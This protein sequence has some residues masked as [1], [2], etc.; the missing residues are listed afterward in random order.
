MSLSGA[1]G[2]AVSGML[3][4]QRQVEVTSGNVSNAQTEGFTAKRA[5]TTTQVLDGRA[6]G[7]LVSDITR[8]GDPF[9]QR[10]LRNEQSGLENAQTKSE[11]FKRVQDLFGT[12]DDDSA[13]ANTLGDLKTRFEEL[14]TEPGNTANQQQVVRQAESVARQ[15]NNL[16]QQ[17][18]ELRAQADADIETAVQT[19]NDQLEN[20]RDLNQNIANADASGDPSANLKDKRDQ[21][22][23]KISQQLDIQTFTRDNG[24]VSVF[25]NDGQ[26]LLNAERGELSFQRTGSFQPGASGNPVEGVDGRNLSPESGGKIGALLELRDQDLPSF[27]EDIDRLAA[28]V[29]EE[30]NAVHNQGTV[31]NS[32][33]QEI[34]GSNQIVDEINSGN[35]QAQQVSVSGEFRIAT[36]D[37]SGNVQ[38]EITIDSSSISTSASNGITVDGS[39]VNGVSGN[40]DT[41]N[42]ADAID[43]A[44]P[45]IGADI[46][47]QGKLEIFSNNSDE[48][49]VI[50]T[51]NFR[52]GSSDP[53]I[54]GDTAEDT[55]GDDNRDR[56][57]SHFFGL[58]NLFETPDNVTPEVNQP[59]LVSGTGVSE[60]TSAANAIEV[61]DDLSEDPNRVSRGIANTTVGAEALPAGDGT[62][63][64]NLAAKFEENVS[65]ESGG[66]VSGRDTTLT[67]FASDILQ[68]QA[69]ESQ[70]LE[71]LAGDRKDVVDNLEFRAESQ[72]GVN[73]DEELARLQ[74]FQQ[75]FNA[76]ARLVSTAQQM[77]Q[78]LSQAVR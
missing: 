70:R 52:V 53:A 68:F 10:E 71:Q 11:V 12:L 44:D 72:A 67:N 60:G 8:E 64:Q 21:A 13:I 24:A 61:R 19:V 56:G 57:F 54:V 46:N 51:D 17:T 40:V 23:Q 63:M 77:F 36:V 1:L 38:K 33:Q 48:Q 62:V 58:N 65:F 43:A 32:G 76:N 41:A 20:L 35:P 66:N 2:N 26:P 27:Q 37:A 78:S 16:S 22:L 9:I 7:T 6:A 75:A 42:I 3:A 50:N 4:S 55:T 28:K 31:G 45:D 49:I 14:G 39:S 34:V 18:Q 5:P 74:Q 30:I 29:T 73:I 59:N 25:T 47:N 69:S 15:L